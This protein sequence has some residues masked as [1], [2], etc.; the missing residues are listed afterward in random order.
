M[1][2]RQVE[3][4]LGETERKGNAGRVTDREREEGF[5]MGEG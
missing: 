4:I 1:G 5:E 2:Q 3:G